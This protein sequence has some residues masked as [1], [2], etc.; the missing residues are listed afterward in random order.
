MIL[1]LLIGTASFVPMAAADYFYLRK[2]PGT[3]RVLFAAGCGLLCASTLWLVWKS[4]PMPSP[5]PLVPAFVC[6][7]L[8]VYTVFFAVK[9]S[10]EALAACPEGMQP[11]VCRG[12]YALCRHPGVLW[13][14]GVYGFL[15]L[16]WPS[17]QW[18]LAFFLFTAGD[19]F[20]VLYQD[21]WIFPHTIHRY[22]EYQK[23][24]PFLIPTVSSINK[25][26]AS[27]SGSSESC[28]KR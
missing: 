23:E 9:P 17:R 18:L 10:R 5:V 15:A 20:Y 6:L 2:R 19:M 27:F 11:L 12:V 26:L 8:L 22:G 16:A 21:R 25:A 14:G 7:V 1:P 28:G 3:G 24:T 4:R 13:L